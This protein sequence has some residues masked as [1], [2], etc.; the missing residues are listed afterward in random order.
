MPKVSLFYTPTFSKQAH[1]TAFVLDSGLGILQGHF[2]FSTFL[3]KN[4][5]RFFK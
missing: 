2:I 1:F 4:G 3:T 5:V